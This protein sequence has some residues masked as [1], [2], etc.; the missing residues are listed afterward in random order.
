MKKLFAVLL[1][2]SMLLSCAA[3]L[4]EVPA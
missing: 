4:A 2:L 3:A 1:A